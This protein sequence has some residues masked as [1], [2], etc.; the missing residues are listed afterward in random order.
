MSSQNKQYETLLIE[1]K[2]NG[3]WLVWPDG[4]AY[5]GPY[6]TPVSARKEILRLTKK[7]R[8]IV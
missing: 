1:P 8:T 4:K 5:A 6:E 3:W 7:T 2:K